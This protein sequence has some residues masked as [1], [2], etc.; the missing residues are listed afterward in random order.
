[1]IV[2]EPSQPKRGE[3]G[4]GGTWIKAPPNSGPLHI[5]RELQPGGRWHLR[6]C[7]A[8][9]RLAA[10]QRCK[11]RAVSKQKVQGHERTVLSLLQYVGPHASRVFAMNVFEAVIAQKKVGMRALA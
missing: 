8:R 9:R 3:K 5:E 2:V 1:M 4:R 7:K 6:A 11:K 10:S